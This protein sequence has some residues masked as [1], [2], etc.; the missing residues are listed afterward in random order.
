MM[1]SL[2]SKGYDSIGEDDLGS[3]VSEAGDGVMICHP[4]LLR[5]LLICW[6]S[7]IRGLLGHSS[8]RWTVVLRRQRSLRECTT[9]H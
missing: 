6:V 1:A 8:D 4:I 7:G 2:R 9:C 5:A 3:M